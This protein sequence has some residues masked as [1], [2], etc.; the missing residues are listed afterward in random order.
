MMQACD[1]PAPRTVEIRD[2]GFDETARTALV[3]GAGG[4]PEEA[5]VALTLLA[6]DPETKAA[7]I[8]VSAPAEAYARLAGEVERLARFYRLKV[9]LVA[10][11]GVNDA[12]DAYQAAVEA[13]SAETLVFLAAGVLPRR[14]GWLS[15]LERAYQARGGRAMVSPTIVFEDDSI[16]FAGTWIEGEGAERRLVDRFIGY[17]RDAV[18]DAEPT[19]VAAGSLQCCAV[20][21]QAF[22]AAGGFTRSY[23]GA[24]DKGRDLC[25][26]LK[27]SGTPSVWLPE[28]EM[29]AADE[30]G[31]RPS[32][33]RRLA[34]RVDR[35][36]F[37]RRWSLLVAN[38]RGM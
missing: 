22:E 11:E 34:Q 38:M 16:R 37:D 1:H 36:C 29:I 35:W 17:P 13:T 20:S 19:E 32:P 15:R 18:R 12:C 8:V 10:S 2:Y 24:A 6:L 21:R 7:A 5:V 3:V 4:D 26:K 33:L 28:V 30:E 27:L 23:L 25:L 9:R 31:G 14:A